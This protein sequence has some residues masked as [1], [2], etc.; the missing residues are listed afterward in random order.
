MWVS[1]FRHL[2]IT[3]YVLLPAAFRSL[4]RLSSALSAK[5]STLRSYWLD[6]LDGMYSVTYL[7]GFGSLSQLTLL[8]PSS[9]KNSCVSS[10]LV[11]L[12]C[13]NMRLLRAFALRIR[14]E[15]LLLSSLLR[16]DRT[17]FP[18]G[19]LMFSQLRRQACSL[20]VHRRLLSLR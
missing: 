4:S 3:G 2:R 9:N 11:N 19:R 18:L 20:S 1:P 6:L 13:D 8:R 16:I 5:A 7:H 14:S 12:F 15:N 10:L 17:R